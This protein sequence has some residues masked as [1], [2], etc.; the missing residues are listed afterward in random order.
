MKKI[1]NSFSRFID[2]YNLDCYNNNDKEVFKA[3]FTENMVTKSILA[4]ELEIDAGDLYVTEYGSEEDYKGFDIINKFTGE[5]YNCK[6]V[7]YKNR[8]TDNY[9]GPIK[10][11]ATYLIFY[12]YC[13]INYD[14][15]IIT[16]PE[17]FYCIST[18][19]YNEIIKDLEIDNKKNT[20][21][22]INKDI[23]KNNS[24]VYKFIIQNIKF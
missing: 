22:L 8:N 5:T 16:F 19:Q 21:Y 20:Y 24:K 6:S 4:Q 11:L 9:S 1:N 23:I 10:S 13:N 15:R 12:D 3:K 7:S 2:R 18:E 17:Y 14:N